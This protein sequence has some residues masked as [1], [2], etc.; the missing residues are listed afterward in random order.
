MATPLHM[1]PLVEQVAM[2]EVGSPHCPSFAFVFLWILICECCD[3]N[4]WWNLLILTDC[5]LCEQVLWEG[6]DCCVRQNLGVDQTGWI[7]KMSHCPSFFPSCS[8]DF[9][10]ILFLYQWCKSAADD[11]DDGIAH[12]VMLM[13][14]A[15]NGWGLWNEIVVFGERQDVCVGHSWWSTTCL[16][17]PLSLVFVWIC[18]VSFFGPN[19]WCK[20]LVLMDCA[21]QARSLKW[22]GLL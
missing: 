3:I 8:F 2:P 5:A 12:E 18:V 10:W 19:T 14:C 16:I 11:D 7:N 15:K 21:M 1:R 20:V 6:M 4:P 9:L 22:E 13:Y 17:V